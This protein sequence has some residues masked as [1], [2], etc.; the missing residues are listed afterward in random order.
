MIDKNPKTYNEL[1][2]LKKCYTLA[3]YYSN[4][5]EDM[6]EEVYNFLGESPKNAIVAN[7]KVLS[8][9]DE[10]SKVVKVFPL[11]PSSSSFDSIKINK[12]GISVIPYYSS[13]SSSYSS[14]SSSNTNNNNNNNN[15]NNS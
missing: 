12:K 14:S 6:F 7:R 5:S 3:N 1:I 9:L 11:I 13:S 10:H 8:L 2:R 15:N 4:I